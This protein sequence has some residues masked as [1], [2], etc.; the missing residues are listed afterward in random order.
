MISLRPARRTALLAAIAAMLAAP[1]AFAQSPPAVPVSVIAAA[2]RDVPVVLGNIGAVQANQSAAIRPRVDG[3]LD[4]VLFTEGQEVRKGDLLARLDPR[5][6]Q[7]ALDQATARRAVTEATLANAR[8]NLARAT[9]LARNQFASRQALDT[10]ASQVAQLE[11]QSRA[12]EAAVKSAQVNLDYTSI[13]APFDGRMGLRNIDPGNVVRFA[14]NTNTAIATISQI[15]P[16]VAVFT[17]PQDAL[18]AIQAAMA[19]GKL[20]VA[21]LSP[22]DRTI[23]AQGELL[24]TDSIIDATTG[25]IRMKAVFANRDT[26]LWPGQFVN[27]RLTL[28]VERGVITVPSSAVQRGPAG[29]FV[30]TINPDQTVALSPVE[31]GQDDGTLAVI[32]RGLDEGARVVVAG[33]SRL[34]AGAKVTINTAPAAAPSAKDTPAPRPA[35]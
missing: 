19:R 4:Q 34:R 32:R 35:G 33:Q 1:P 31:L 16:I 24:A 14:D 18:P 28:E 20:P 3:M 12:D 15:H 10:A 23:L 27:I 6:Y 11:A 5:P 17:L 30:Y 25:T 21:A 7:A 13:T 26:K 8:L 29:L 9:D 2:R 22:D